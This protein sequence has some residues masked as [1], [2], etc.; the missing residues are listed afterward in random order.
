MKVDFNV[1]V[2]C[3]KCSKDFNAFDSDPNLKLLLPLQDEGGY[4]VKAICPDCKT[5]CGEISVMLTI[6]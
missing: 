5:D 2:T 4:S 1:P 3:C 6:K